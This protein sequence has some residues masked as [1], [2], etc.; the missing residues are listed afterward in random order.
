MVPINLGLIDRPSVP[1]NLISAQESQF[2]MAP[3]LKILMS[4]GSKKGTQMYCPFLSKVPASESPPGPHCGPYGE[5]YPYPE[6]F[7]SYLPGSPVQEPSPKALHAEPLQRETLYSKSPHH[8]SLKVPGM[9]AP[10][11]VPL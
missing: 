6:P 7:L 9:L 10:F 3:K 4:S 11:Q 5:R 8:P 2:Q 1:R